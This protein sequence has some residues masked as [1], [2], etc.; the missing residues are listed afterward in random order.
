MS[1]YWI[2]R[3]ELRKACTLKHGA[4]QAT[5]FGLIPSMRIGYVTT[6]SASDVNNW[7]GL[8]L[9]IREALRQAGNE[10]HDI[11]NLPVIVP[12]KTRLRGW[13]HRFLRGRVYGYHYDVDMA[14]AF[15]G[16][17]ERRLA[18]KDLDCLVSP[19]SYAFSMLRTR[20]PCASWGD[21]TFHALFA[22]YPWFEGF[23]EVS[24]EHAHELQRRSLGHCV[25]N[26]YPSQWAADDA[27]NYYHADP[28]SV[29]VVPY[30]ANCDPAFGSEED[31]MAAVHQRSLSPLRLLFVGG[32]WE[33][34]GGPLALQVL[35]ELQCRHVPAELWVVGCHP[36]QGQPP[37]GVKC[38]GFLSKS[39]PHEREQWERCFR[40][41]HAFILP[42]RAECFGVVFAEAASYALPSLAT[43]TG[44][45]P[46]AAKE[47]GN[48]WL[49][50]VAA[51]AAE[52]ADL[53]ESW[54]NN[55]GAYHD[56][57]MRAWLYSAT[58]LNWKAAGSRFTELL[59]ARID[60]EP[61]EVG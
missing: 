19:G 30:G 8:V 52:Y 45:V 35:Q 42:T 48:G 39:E 60:L 23:A 59:T 55:G 4:D 21:A 36:F 31:A 40:D 41:C 2:F 15:A 16:E 14:R 49:F 24:T 18:G 28:A 43:R 46:D 13:Y 20:L 9:H 47:G 61:T 38:F 1:F 58:H 22:H 27:L 51:R 32:D 33:R 54:V 57:A 44:G 25:L 12:A 50:D 26:C 3:I 6:G 5:I 53:L 37:P 17:V 29:A 56:A 34:K 11:D 7:S 10:I